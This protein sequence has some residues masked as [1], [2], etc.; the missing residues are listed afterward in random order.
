MYGLPPGASSPKRECP[1]L[2]IKHTLW[3]RRAW[4]PTLRKMIGHDCDVEPAMLRLFPL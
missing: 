1:E 2:C 4:W 3:G